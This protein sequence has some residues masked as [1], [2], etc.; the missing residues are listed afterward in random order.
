MEKQTYNY[1]DLKVW[2]EA[3]NLVEKIYQLSK[4]FPKN[5]QYGITSQLRRAAIS[6]PLNIAE[7]QGRSSKKEFQQFL[8][9][10]RGSIYE[11]NTI[12]LLCHRLNYLTK[13]N[14]QKLRQ[15]INQIT[16]MLSGL[17]NSL[18]I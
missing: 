1:E 14:Y 7:G 3:M 5:E 15:Q 2:Q 17:I 16:R 13:E 4:I 6:I 11:T 9:I 8:M 10:A 12:L 18:R